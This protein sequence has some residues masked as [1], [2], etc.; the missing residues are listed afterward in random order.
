MGG[1]VHVLKNALP[2]TI[3]AVCIARRK[4][5]DTVVHTVSPLRSK[6]RTQSVRSRHI[7]LKPT[8]CERDHDEKLNYVEPAVALRLKARI[9][10]VRR[11]KWAPASSDEI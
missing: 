3:D 7:V 9:R 10:S 6:T 2:T 1:W 4:K 8:E 11:S 5:K